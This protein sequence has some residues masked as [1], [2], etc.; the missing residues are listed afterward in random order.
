M[1]LQTDMIV[2]AIDEAT[3]EQ[4]DGNIMTIGSLIEKLDTFDP[5]LDIMFVYPDD[6]ED[7]LDYGEYEK[8][9]TANML[10][11]GSFDS[12]RGYYRYMAIAP[13]FIIG[14][15]G[16]VITELQRSLGEVFEGYKGGDYE[17]K[18]DTFVWCS[19]YGQA[20]TLMIVDVIQT[21]NAVQVITAFENTD[22]YDHEKAAE[23]AKRYYHE[24]IG[25]KVL[26]VKDG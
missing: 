14:T 19:H 11:L 2:K 18:E 25:R 5:R 13:A 8:G 7:I 20:S 3:H 22:D 16:A 6:P 12:Y 26:G 17:M 15:V 10:G 4:L 23:N 1:S 9:Y 21:E 24:A